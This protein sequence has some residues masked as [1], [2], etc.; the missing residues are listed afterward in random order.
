MPFADFFREQIRGKPGARR[1]RR[2]QKLQRTYAIRYLKMIQADA[3][4][5]DKHAVRLLTLARLDRCAHA[6]LILESLREEVARL[7]TRALSFLLDKA[8]AEA[9]EVE[10]LRSAYES[11][12]RGWVGRKSRAPK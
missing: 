5:G 6:S 4:K 8:R 7:E 2:E 11:S 10:N 9:H 1:E 12:Q 3:A